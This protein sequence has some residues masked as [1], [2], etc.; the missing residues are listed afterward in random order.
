M[1]ADRNA[2]RTVLWGAVLAPTAVVLLLMA[3]GLVV[4]QNLWKVADPA[5]HRPIGQAAGIVAFVSI[6]FG[7]LLIYPIARARGAPLWIVMLACLVTPVAWNVKEMVRVLQF[8]T[9]PEALWWGLN[10][11]FILAFVGA[12]GQMGLCEL[13]LRLRRC[14][15]GS[16]VRVLTFAPVLAVVLSLVA[17]YFLLI[18]GGGVHTFY[19]YMEGYRALLN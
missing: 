12:W 10:P 3:V 19:L 8:F 13:L 2:A 1:S 15:T 14:M 6:G 5:V 16:P 9:A 11:G 17:L 4:H 7:S 18:W